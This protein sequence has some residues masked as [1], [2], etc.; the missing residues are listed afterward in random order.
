MKRE[1]VYVDVF[2]QAALKEAERAL[3]EGE[4]PVGCVLVHFR[5]NEAAAAHVLTDTTTEA[6]PASWRS[7]IAACGRNAT[8]ARRHAL[9]HAEFVAV[10]MLA[11]NQWRLSSTR[12]SAAT[13]APCGKQPSA[14]T[15]TG[16]H[17]LLS[18]GKHEEGED[19][20]QMTAS[21]EGEEEQRSEAYG[22]VDTES[23]GGTRSIGRATSTSTSAVATGGDV[24]GSALTDLS[25]YVLYVTVEP[26]VMCAAFLLYN[27]IGHVFFGCP[28]PRFGGN[29]TVLAL[30]DAQQNMFSPQPPVVPR[31][32]ETTCDEAHGGACNSHCADVSNGREGDKEAHYV[33]EGGCSRP[34]CTACAACFSSLSP[35]LS[36]C[37]LSPTSKAALKTVKENGSVQSRCDQSSSSHL[38]TSAHV[39]CTHKPCFCS[40]PA[41]GDGSVDYH[42]RHSANGGKGV[43][44]TGGGWGYSS[45]GGYRGPDAIALLQRFY[46]NENPNAP[47]HKRRRKGCSDPT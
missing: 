23:G 32:T 18:E 45:E 21:W 37:L 46:A 3:S 19:E 2:M 38:L 4:V 36:L 16:T 6:V 22:K 31:P 11:R 24:R 5:D 15:R 1:A 33:S 47:G 39:F 30:H 28:N 44:G 13:A 43:Q 25:S 35:P 34:S 7:A 42:H 20:V 41:V 40:G 29:G 14:P 10:E 8:N 27:R 26:C 17:E 9:A 12:S